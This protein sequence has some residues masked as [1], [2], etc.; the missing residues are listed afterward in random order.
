MAQEIEYKFIITNLDEVAK[1]DPIR[2]ENIRQAYLTDPKS[3]ANVRV[4]HS[5]HSDGTVS[6]FVTVKSPAKG[7]SRGE[8]EYQIPE[9][10]YAEI[11]ELKQGVEIAKTRYFFQHGKHV[12]ELDI[13]EGALAGLIIA[14]IEVNSEDEEVEFPSWFGRD[15]TRDYRYTNSSLAQYGLPK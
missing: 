1:L 14:E 15:V 4:R 5:A 8:W 12:I 9:A 10:D 13:F 11:S 2:Y 3:K 7:M 6:A